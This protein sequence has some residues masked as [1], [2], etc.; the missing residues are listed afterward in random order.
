MEEHATVEL[1]IQALGWV[2]HLDSDVIWDYRS[3]LKRK[4]VQEL[5]AKVISV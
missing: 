2:V 1:G 4:E 5:G 3:C